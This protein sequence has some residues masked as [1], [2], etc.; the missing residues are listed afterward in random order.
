MGI[1]LTSVV[2]S[3]TYLAPDKEC[4]NAVIA[5]IKDGYRLIDTAVAYANQKAVGNAIKK[6][7]DEGI[8]KREELFIT[9]KLWLTEWKPEDVEK[10]VKICLEELQLDYIDLFL[11]HQSVL[12]N[13]PKDLD[14]KRRKGYFFDRPLIPEDDPKYRLGYNIDNLK[15]TWGKMEELC[16]AGLLHSIGVS[17]FSA[18]RVNDVL[19]F[20]SIKPAV[21]QIELHPY[22]QQW[23][24]KETLAKNDI[25]LMAY[26]PLGGAA[27]VRAGDVAG[28]MD[29]PVIKRIAENH[30]K[31]PAQIMIRWA[32]QRG[33][34]CIP[35]S[36]HEER[37]KENCNIFDFEL[38]EEEMSEMKALDKRFRFVRIDA[39]VPS[40]QTWR[41]IWDGEYVDNYRCLF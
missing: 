25:Y 7:I 3:R 29:D 16:R 4:E 33:T 27:H 2:I 5:A 10:S 14:E 37:I 40:P 6:C 1:L 39:L 22:L 9:T 21:N 34:I 41:D 23:E 12:M 31:T 26:F 38:S 30:H 15:Q 20:C 35:K 24:T 36:V 13:L 32:V 19:S 8:V 28:P 17:N 11:V 18:K